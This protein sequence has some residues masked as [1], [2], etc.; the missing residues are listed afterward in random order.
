MITSVSACI[1]VDTPP[2]IEITVLDSFNNVVS[3]A[4]VAI[5]DNQ[6]EWAMRENPL[7][8]WKKT[9]I[10]GKVLFLNLQER[11]YYVFAEKGNLSNLKT[12]ILTNN[13]LLVNQIQSLRIHID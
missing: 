13:K 9:D 5:F 11:N 10:N 8:V 3:D 12:E 1:K 7:Q 2:A 4:L 6:D